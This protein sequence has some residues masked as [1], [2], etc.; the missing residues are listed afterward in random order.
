MP[1][2]VSVQVHGTWSWLSYQPTGT[3]K[4]S[5]AASQRTL[6]REPLM[7]WSAAGPASVPASG[8]P[9][10]ASVPASVAGAWT[11]P[12]AAAH[13]SAIEARRSDHRGDFVEP[14]RA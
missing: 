11:L 13:A 8:E 3:R 9:A 7:G 6:S 2:V 12:H 14:G 10:V 5:A 4:P 1:S